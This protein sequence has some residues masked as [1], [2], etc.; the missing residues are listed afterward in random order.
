MKMNFLLDMGIAEINHLLEMC[1][2][3]KVFIENALNVSI[4]QT[5]PF[6]PTDEHLQKYC[7]ILKKNY[8]NEKVE[9]IECRFAGY[10]Y[11]TE[12]EVNLPDMKETNKELEV[13]DI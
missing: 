5:V 11:L 1:G 9:C 7:E 6:I 12:H 10:E 4:E 3:D 13:E 8:T 2:G